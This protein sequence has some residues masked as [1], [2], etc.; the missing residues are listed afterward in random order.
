[1][2]KGTNPRRKEIT[3]IAHRPLSKFRV[4]DEKYNGTPVNGAKDLRE[5]VNVAHDNNIN[6]SMMSNGPT[7]DVAVARNE[8]NRVSSE[9]Q[10]VIQDRCF[11]QKYLRAS[12]SAEK[13]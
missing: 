6:K 1:M 8:G 12:V 9:V 7:L 11:E 13:N 2:L 5:M 4:A 3:Q 10:N